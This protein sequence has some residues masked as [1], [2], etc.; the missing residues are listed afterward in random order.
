MGDTG[1]IQGRYRG[2]NHRDEAVGLHHALDDVGEIQGRYRGDIGEITRSP[3]SR[4]RRRY[5]GDVGGVWGEGRG[6]PAVVAQLEIQGRY[7]GD[8]GEI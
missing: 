4:K 8:I 3:A 2:D 1:E 5:R 7:R 6:A